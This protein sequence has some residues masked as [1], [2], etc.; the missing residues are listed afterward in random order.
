MANMWGSTELQIVVGTA[1][2]AG[3][4]GV[5]V[6]NELIPKPTDLGVISSVVQQKG[7]KRRKY[8]ARICV[9]TVEEY[10]DFIDT[11]DAGTKQDLSITVLGISALSCLIDSVGEPDFQF[12]DQIYFD[13]VWME[14]A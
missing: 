9:A 1:K 2:F 11:A 4:A 8:K 7:R 6:E 3:L 13:V 14:V 5:L 12:W 10:W